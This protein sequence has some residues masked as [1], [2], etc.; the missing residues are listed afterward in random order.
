[1]GVVCAQ[2]TITM[3][4]EWC[5]NMTSS[6]W[7]TRVSVCKWLCVCL[8]HH[9]SVCV[10]VCVCL[11]PSV[12][13]CILCVVCVCLGVCRGLYVYVCVRERVCVSVCSPV[14]KWCLKSKIDRYYIWFFNAQSSTEVISSPS[15]YFEHRRWN[16]T[17]SSSSFYT[18]VQNTKIE[19]CLW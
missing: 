5:L 1:M 16:T 15:R 14:W 3:M 19:N 9:L 2:C 12:C 13:L 8:S 11:C 4:I 18:R 6:I 10:R 7:F 17:L